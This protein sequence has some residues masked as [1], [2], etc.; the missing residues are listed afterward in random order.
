MDPNGE[1]LPVHGTGGRE[2][3]AGRELTFE[4]MLAQ[5]E[6]SDPVD[7]AT[8]QGRPT[9]ALPTLA[10]DDD[11]ISVDAGLGGLDLDGMLADMATAST[12]EARAAVRKQAERLLRSITVDAAADRGSSPSGESPLP[13]VVHNTLDGALFAAFDPDD[14]AMTVDDTTEA[15]I[16][17][18]V[19][20]GGGYGMTAATLAG[21]VASI[22]TRYLALSDGHATVDPEEPHVVI[23][24]TMLAAKPKLASLCD[25]VAVPDL[26]LPLPQAAAFA[27]FLE[28][29][30]AFWGNLVRKG[31]TIV[32]NSSRA[33]SRGGG[34]YEPREKTIYMSLLG[35][36]PPGAFVRLLVHETGHALFESTL[37][38]DHP[39]PPLL[40]A[41]KADGLPSEYDPLPTGVHE[42]K[43]LTQLGH[44]VQQLQ[45]YWDRMSVH[46]KTFYH[47]WLTLRD[48]RQHLLG[49]DLWRDPKGNRL[50]PGQR[51]SYQAGKFDEF[52]AEVFMQYAMGDL[53]P[54]LVTLLADPEVGDPVKLAWRNAWQVL[55]TVAAP[56][57]L[58][59]PHG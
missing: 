5:M 28:V 30:P 1:G 40:T 26:D 7:G 15:G 14:L 9:R 22:K 55:E 56:L 3:G 8:H 19:I 27:H 44:E 16:I 29:Y 50:S 4:E 54:H 6:D 43:D 25:R 23:L 37:L 53:R 58:G 20:A 41:G 35:V 36:T 10:D 34:L 48:H 32:F 57:L 42:D 52:C 47:A 46:A 21:P 18:L 17:Q 13:V 59:P 51:R 38:D 33:N 49:L 12:G 11:T 31:C 39:M 24:S 2:P 45:D